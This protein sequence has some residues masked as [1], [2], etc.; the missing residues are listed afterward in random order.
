[1]GRVGM[2]ERFCSQDEE[3]LFAVALGD[4]ATE[5]SIQSKA[6]VF[7]ALKQLLA[8]QSLSPSLSFCL[9]FFLFLGTLTSSTPMYSF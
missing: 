8:K 2:L 7:E 1:M 5:N 9:S 3:Q 6:S 4:V